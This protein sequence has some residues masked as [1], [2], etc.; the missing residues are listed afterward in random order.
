MNYLA[1]TYAEMGKNL[2]LAESLARQAV[3]LAPQDGYILDT[4]G[5]V[6]FKLGKYEASASYLELASQ[7]EPTEEIIIVHLAEVYLRL[8]KSL[9]AKKLLEKALKLELT[10]ERKVEIQA[11][12][13]NLFDRT[14]VREPASEP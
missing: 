7:K 11:K 14:S 8:N 4:L 5:W 3:K 2:K 9:Q 13:Q 10:E 6:L 1:F 12:L